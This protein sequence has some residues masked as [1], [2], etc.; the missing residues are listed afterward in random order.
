MDLSDFDDVHRFGAAVVESFSAL[1]FL[2]L[3]AGMSH[4]IAPPAYTAMWDRRWLS[5][6]GHSKVYASNHLGHFLLAVLLAPHLAHGAS[7]VVVGSLSMWWGDPGKLMLSY[8]HPNQAMAGVEV[9][10]RH[11][12]F[13]E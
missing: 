10:D 7:V 5:R 2:V 9:A 11:A 13:G 8:G 12:M 6:S 3:N 4:A 1:H